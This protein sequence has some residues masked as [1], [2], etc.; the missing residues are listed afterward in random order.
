MSSPP[1]TCPLM[2]EILGNRTKTKS[3][4]SQIPSYSNALTDILPKLL[5]NL[6]TSASDFYQKLSCLGQGIN[7]TSELLGLPTGELTQERTERGSPESGH[8]CTS[9]WM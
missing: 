8:L 7:R 3:L 4:K 6:L 1:D 5:T 2:L 9:V